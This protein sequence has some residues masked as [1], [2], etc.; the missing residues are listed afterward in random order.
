[1][2]TDA[3]RYGELR[4]R[5][6]RSATVAVRTDGSTVNCLRALMSTPG[7]DTLTPTLWVFPSRSSSVGS[8]VTT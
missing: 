1:M 3:G 2:G 6:R 8:N 4:A 7:V 5:D